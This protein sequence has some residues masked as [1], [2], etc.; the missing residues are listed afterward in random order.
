M[1]NDEFDYGPD[2]F[3]TRARI[4]RAGGTSAHP[5]T[6]FIAEHL[7]MLVRLVRTLSPAERGVLVAN[8]NVL[9]DRSHSL[10]DAAIYGAMSG[11][12]NRAPAPDAQSWASD[13]QKMQERLAAARATHDKLAGAEAASRAADSLVHYFRVAIEPGHD[14]R[15]TDDMVGEIRAIVTDIVRAARGE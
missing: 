8:L 6:T 5:T 9:A 2:P 14:I 13:P 1:M 4:I 12:A 15:V 3:G 10:H 11:W 7:A